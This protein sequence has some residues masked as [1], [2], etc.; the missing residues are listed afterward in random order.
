[1][2]FPTFYRLMLIWIFR[3]KPIRWRFTITHQ[4]HSPWQPLVVGWLSNWTPDHFTPYTWIE[5]HERISFRCWK[6]WAKRPNRAEIR[7]E[8]LLWSHSRWFQRRNAHRCCVINAM[9]SYLGPVDSRSTHLW[10]FSCPFSEP[11]FTPSLLLS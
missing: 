6:S 11:F 8:D 7:L 10:F 1:M 9:V 2:Y 3:W 4:N 5:Y